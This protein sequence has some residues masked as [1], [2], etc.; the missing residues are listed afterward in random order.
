MQYPETT[1]H[2][3]HFDTHITILPWQQGKTNILYCLKLRPV[4]YKHLVTFS[5]QGK[6]HY[7]KNKHWDLN[8]HQVFC[9]SIIIIFTY[10]VL[11]SLFLYSLFQL[12]IWDTG[13][14]TTEPL[15]VIKYHIICEFLTECSPLSEYPLP[16]PLQIYC[17]NL[18]NVQQAP[19]PGC[20]VLLLWPHRF[21]N[22]VTSCPFHGALYL[23]NLLHK[24]H[25]QPLQFI[26]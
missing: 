15:G 16:L 10:I 4:S 3:I 17:V 23:V 5:G 9:R 20:V 19:S 13:Q 8:K 18:W 6:Q 1:V 24:R 26:T 21:I 12:Y 25:Q 22:M 2:T 11:L 14:R 7:N